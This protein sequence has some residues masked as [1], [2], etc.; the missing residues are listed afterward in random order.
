MHERIKLGMVGGGQG[1][2]IGAVHRIAARL[3]DR[4][5]LVAGALSSNPERAASSAAELGIEQTR[6]YASFEDMAIKEAARPDGIKAVSV[7]TPNHMH[8]P[9]AKAFLN[10]GITVICDKPLT[11]TLADAEE[12]GRIV[13]SSSAEFILTHNYS[14]YPMVRQ[15]REMVQTGELGNLRRVQVEY[16]QDWLSTAIKKGEN[17]QADWRADPDK[18]G[19]GGAIADI[20]THAFQ[21]SQFI[22]GE[23]ATEVSADLTAFIEGRMVDDDAHMM[24]RYESGAK[25]Y[26]W[27]SQVSPGHENGLRIRVYGDKGSLDWNQENPNQLW[28]GMLGE[29]RKMLTRGGHGAYDIS[30]C[31]TR[32]PSGH[33]EGYL[34]GFAT[35]YKEAADIIKNGRP[36]D[37]LSPTVEEGILGMRFI[38]AA[39][40]SSK[41]NSAWTAV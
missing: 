17:K 35:I 13:E 3:D 18:S 39:I 10:A 5:E 8:F 1:A 12:L 9:V 41:T 19:Q 4:F 36:D 38:E 40:H 16:V 7:G 14:G 28:V 27:A 23:A 2:F 25:G 22:C 20:G 31:A 24:M 34:E 32:V 37:S 26:L 21:L 30:N 6:S 11:S 15:A 33:P 29:P